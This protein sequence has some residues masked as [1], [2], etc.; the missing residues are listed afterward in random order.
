[1]H[2]SVNT[3][4]VTRFPVLSEPETAFSPDQPSEALHEV[5]LLEDHISVDALPKATELG[6]AE[7]V[8]VVG[9]T[10]EEPLNS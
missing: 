6:L 3:V 10:D 2:V 1:M 8:A 4:S 7:R 5:A 9:C